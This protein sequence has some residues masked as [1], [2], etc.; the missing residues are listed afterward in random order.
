M[1]GDEKKQGWGWPQRSKKAHWFH[2]AMSLCRKWMF[3]GELDS[4][5]VVPLQRG[6]DDCAACYRL[7]VK[8]HKA[9]SAKVSP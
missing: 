5:S 1:S 2:G 4:G 9:A 7:L 3:T 8:E 6:P